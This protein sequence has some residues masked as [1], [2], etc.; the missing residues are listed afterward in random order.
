MPYRDRDYYAMRPTI[1]I[2]APGSP[3]LPPGEKACLP[4]TRWFGLHPAMAPLQPLWEKK[5]LAPIV[6]HALYDLVALIWL[7]RGAARRRAE[8]RGAMDGD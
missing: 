3:D 8:P 4:L 2:A 6:T 1:A 7:T 5:M